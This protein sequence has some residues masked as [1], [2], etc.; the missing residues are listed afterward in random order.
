MAWKGGEY[1]Q[2]C[3][4]EDIKNNV[5]DLKRRLTPLPCSEHGHP[6][7]IS[8]RQGAWV[9][10]YNVIAPYSPTPQALPDSLIA[11]I[12]D[13]YGIRFTEAFFWLSLI[14]REVQKR[15]ASPGV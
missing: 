8:A 3:L 6:A 15:D 9:D 11:R 5:P 7:W 4:E 12:C 13:D 10:F 2:K 1:C 14:H